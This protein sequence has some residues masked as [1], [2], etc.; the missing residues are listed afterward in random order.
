MNT[1][2]PQ[3]ELLALWSSPTAEWRGKPFWSW[4]GKLEKDELIRQIHVMKEMGFGGFFMH[5]RTGL[6]TEYLGDEWFDLINACADEAERLGME[7]WLYDEDRWPSGSAGGIATRDP[8]YRMRYLRMEITESEKFEWR[9]E[10]LAAFTCSTDGFHGEGMHYHEGKRI[11][12]EESKHIPPG[13]KVLTFH[14]EVMDEGSFYN[15]AAYLD[16]MNPEATRHFL[17]VTHERYV[18]KCGDRLGKSIKGIFTDEPHRGMVMSSF[19]DHTHSSW[20]IPW[21][22]RL[23]DEFESRFGYD[24]IDNLP[25]I[26]L[27]P[28]GQDIVQVKWHYMELLQSLF[29]ENF[30]RPVH[31]W[32][33]EHDLLLTG[34]LLHE[35]NLCCQSVP[36]GSMMRN[37]EFMDFPG[38]DILTEG[39]V[40]FNVAKQL[41]SAARQL[42]KP[43]LLSELYGCTG[44]QMSFENHK[45]VGDWQALFGINVR[46]PHLSWY[47]MEGQAKRDYPASILHQ[48]AWYP[49]YHYVEDYFSRISI[50]LRQGKPVC[51]LLVLNP[52]ESVWAQIRHGWVNHLTG[53]T[54]P[55][56][57]L[58]ST[59]D[60]VF[61]WLSGVQLDFDYGDEDFLMRMG[62]VETTDEGPVLVVGKAR[63]KAVL[64]AGLTTI[65]S[66]TLDLL[67]AYAEAGGKLIFTGDPPTNVDAVS[68]NRAMELR[69]RNL[70]VPFYQDALTRACRKVTPPAV[71]V[72]DPEYGYNVPSIFA[73]T[74][75]CDDGRFVMLVRTQRERWLR[76][77]LVRLRGSGAVE[78]WDCRSGKRTR[79]NA[80]EA[81]GWLEFEA[82][83]GPSGEHLYRVVEKAD[84]A[85]PAHIP[86]S[87]TGRKT[88][89]IEFPYRLHEPNV[90]VLDHASFMIDGGEWQMPLEIL[91]IDRAIRRSLDLEVRG[92]T[93]LQPWFT[94]DQET[95]T[96]ARIR[97]KF[98]FFIDTLPSEPV[99]LV[100]E[101]PTQYASIKINGKPLDP[102]S[103]EGWWVDQC[104][105]PLPVPPGTL[106]VGA[107]SVELEF[108]F[109]HGTNLEALFLT[110]TFGVQ[111]EGTKASL[112]T[113]PERLKPG[114]LTRQGLPFY[115]AGITYRIP[116]DAI[117]RP[118]GAD[119]ATRAWLHL[120]KFEAACALVSNA[121]D[122][123]SMIAFEPHEA[124]LTKARPDCEF[125]DLELILT[126]R[127]TFGPLHQ[128]PLRDFWY[129]P[130]NWITEGG[131]F[132]E[133]WM[134]FPAGLLEAPEVIWKTPNSSVD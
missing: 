110:G 109:H 31:E 49:H 76:G 26:F 123:P 89:D 68:S 56:Q 77:I 133:E 105:H 87:E 107:N 130:E 17:D 41:L 103:R 30:M 28:F 94:K 45:S 81:D 50:A 99:S 25:E 120:P 38:I 98:E 64:V 4:N 7:A 95:E 16:T 58:E 71:E 22:D 53:S 112:T 6:V 127:N 33:R 117:T 91:K 97:L 2:L 63:Y 90:L 124:E 128:I 116:T 37:Y 1:P 42:D 46:C 14:I 88:L 29:L 108:D 72:L 20:V 44:W 73:Q 19:A 67:D 119:E 132:S 102:A 43:W 47:T 24:L 79:I 69:D 27:Q 11:T 62:T 35:D 126:R 10:L 86:M 51:D 59:Y 118:D 13:L 84:A 54:T 15:G 39:N 3:P 21:S 18:E 5:S 115:G 74:R 57:V 61:K 101:Q 93:M 100:L 75:D 113:L 92:G 83:F 65:R 66:T 122:E 78:E 12:R 85:L 40:R 60:N 8:K 96:L 23:C 82:D 131:A 9:D 70:Y 129:G 52:V 34:H 55:I 111:L 125:I 104:M 114:C 32:C 80:R 121:E 106:Q 36:N 134:L 48:S